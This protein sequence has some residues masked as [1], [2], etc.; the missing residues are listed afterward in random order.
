MKHIT[1]SIAAL[2]S[3]MMAS[4]RVHVRMDERVTVSD[5]TGNDLLRLCSSHEPFEANM[6]I[7][8]V[9]GVRDGAAWASLKQAFPPES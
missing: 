1:L 3:L 8:Y 7:G 9:E 6:C 2:L 5:L 4:E